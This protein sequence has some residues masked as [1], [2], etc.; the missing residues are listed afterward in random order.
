MTP[1]GKQLG[2]RADEAGAPHDQATVAEQRFGDLRLTGERLAEK[3]T[4]IIGLW[5]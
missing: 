5:E 2:L 4:P 1:V 3:L